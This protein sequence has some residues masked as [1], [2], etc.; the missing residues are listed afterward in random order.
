M[1]IEEINKKIHQCTTAKRFIHLQLF[2]AVSKH[3][4]ARVEK[5]AKAL[6]ETIEE[7]KRLQDLQGSM[8]NSNTR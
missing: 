1:T 7:L 2:K 3:D 5:R 8:V 4:L 6:V